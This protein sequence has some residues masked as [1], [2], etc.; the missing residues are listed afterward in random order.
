MTH[1]KMGKRSRHFSRQDIQMDNDHKKRYLMLLVTVCL[2][3]VSLTLYDP[4]DCSSPGSSARGILQARILEWVACPFSRGSSQPR[5][6]NQNHSKIP[7]HTYQ[8]WL[9]SKSQKT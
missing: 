7:P 6:T 4:I 8:E 2:M 3:C 5:N 9:E 1:L